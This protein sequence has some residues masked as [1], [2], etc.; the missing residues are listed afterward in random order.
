MSGS[1][2]SSAEE[3]LEWF[4]ACDT[5]GGVNVRGKEGFGEQLV[6]VLVQGFIKAPACE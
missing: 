6:A 5:C 1:S 3:N 2:F 4:I